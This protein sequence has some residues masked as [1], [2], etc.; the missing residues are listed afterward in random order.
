[1]YSR[2]TCANGV[3]L[4][5]HL[6]PMSRHGM[7]KVSSQFRM[8]FIVMYSRELNGGLYFSKLENQKAVSDFA[9]DCRSC[10][11]IKYN[12][13]FRISFLYNRQCYGC[14]I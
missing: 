3:I 7:Y 2:R 1:M 8:Q 4:Q 6:M 13:I 12:E 5:W 14:T 9:K 11:D 10:D